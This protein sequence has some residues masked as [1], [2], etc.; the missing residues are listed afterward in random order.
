MQTLSHRTNVSI[1]KRELA[2]GRC[3]LSPIPQRH[4]G[5]NVTYPE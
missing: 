3:Q 1:G 5:K 2:A 4:A